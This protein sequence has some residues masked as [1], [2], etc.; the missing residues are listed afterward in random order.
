MLKANDNAKAI[1]TSNI[2]IGMQK[3][4]DCFE[5]KVHFIPMKHGSLFFITQYRFL[6]YEGAGLVGVKIRT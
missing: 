3:K 2:F 1:Q 6:C 5:C 4:N